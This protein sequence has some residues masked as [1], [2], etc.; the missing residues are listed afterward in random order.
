M[1]RYCARLPVP[2]VCERGRLL[3]SEQTRFNHTLPRSRE[4]DGVAVQV[5]ECGTLGPASPLAEAVEVLLAVDRGWV[6]LVAPTACEGQVRGRGVGR[7]WGEGE[8]CAR[9][10]GVVVGGEGRVPERPL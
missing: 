9:R 5:L 2:V 8:G 3:H 4:T 6:F 7:G 10:V 1:R